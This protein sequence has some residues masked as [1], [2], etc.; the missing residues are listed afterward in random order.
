[1]VGT[2]PCLYLACVIGGVAYVSL[3]ASASLPFDSRTR[4]CFCCP[5]F[6]LRSVYRVFLASLP[7]MFVLIGT[8]FRGAV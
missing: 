7:A 3:W 2:T 1:M 6:L 5:P 8:P 4:G